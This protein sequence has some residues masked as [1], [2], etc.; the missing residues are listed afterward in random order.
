[1][2]ALCPYVPCR[3]QSGGGNLEIGKAETMNS[4]QGTMGSAVGD[5]RRAL[6]EEV[7]VGYKR[8]EF[9]LLPN[10]WYAVLLG[11]LFV[12]KNGPKYTTVKLAHIVGRV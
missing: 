3:S 2:E 6:A 4:G 7:P 8:T 9:G 1:M 10:A 11:D 12:F 5:E